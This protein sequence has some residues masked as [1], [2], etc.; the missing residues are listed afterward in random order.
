M[1]KININ[2]NDDLYNYCRNVDSIVKKQFNKIDEKEIFKYILYISM[3]GTF[4]T[5]KNL[6]IYSEYKYKEKEILKDLFN[7]KLMFFNFKSPLFHIEEIKFS[8][9]LSKNKINEISKV[10]IVKNLY[11]NTEV[12]VLIT[13]QFK[14]KFDFIYDNEIINY[15]LNIINY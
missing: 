11:N 15:N 10:Y 8:P 14:N 12:K 6:S 13:L 4:I 5:D 7:K 3:L 2:L 9:I 1:E